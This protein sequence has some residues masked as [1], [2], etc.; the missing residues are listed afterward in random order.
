MKK[1]ITSLALMFCICATAQ[2]NTE[3][4]Y[5]FVHRSN[6][7]VD[8][9]PVS[10]IDSIV[11]VTPPVVETPDNPTMAEAVDLGLS[12]KWASCNV[13]ASSPEEQGN[14]YAWGEVEPKDNYTWETYKWCDGT[15]DSMLKYC[16]NGEYSY[17][18]I[19]N[20]TV[21]DLEDDAAHVNMGGNWRMPTYDEFNELRKN[22]TIIST[23]YKGVKGH[24]VVGPNGNSIFLPVGFYV[25]GTKVL[26]P[27]SIYWTASLN[28]NV[29][30]EAYEFC[31]FITGS[32]SANK[33]NWFISAARYYGHVVRAVCE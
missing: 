1:I 13:G 5:M 10:E 8:S 27:F 2:N 3:I 16:T 22:C 21:L 15:E 29:S 26:A 9:I 33:Y 11:F 25:D 7:A 6:N 12:V 20:K 17:N 19:D 24:K 32:S 23:T 28:D 31:P 4:E 30:N 18:I 14:Y